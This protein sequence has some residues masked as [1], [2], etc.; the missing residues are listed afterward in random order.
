METKIGAPAPSAQGREFSYPTAIFVSLRQRRLCA[1]STEEPVSIGEGLPAPAALPPLDP[2]L[3]FDFSKAFDV[4]SQ[5]I[6]LQN[7]H[8]LVFLDLSLTRA[9]LGSP[10][11]LHRLGGRISPPPLV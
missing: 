6:L 2:S 3:L 5:T 8:A 4:V 10:A 1:F 11:N 9:E 7:Y